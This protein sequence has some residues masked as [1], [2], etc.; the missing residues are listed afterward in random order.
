MKHTLV[1]ILFKF[2]FLEPKVSYSILPSM[3][4]LPWFVF[5]MFFLPS[6]ENFC[7]PAISLK[8]LIRYQM[9]KSLNVLTAESMPHLEIYITWCVSLQSPVL[10]GLLEETALRDHLSFLNICGSSVYTDGVNILDLQFW[11]NYS[12]AIFFVLIIDG[13]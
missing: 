4:S 12:K 1:N 3:G 13:S 11:P 6:F 2:R 9:R 5:L 10:T 7:K 8:N